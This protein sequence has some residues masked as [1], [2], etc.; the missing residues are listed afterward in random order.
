[1]LAYTFWH[2][3]RPDVSPET[4]EARQR[5][6]QATLAAHPPDGFQQGTTVRL[7]GAPWA[8]EGRTAY[9]DWYL[10]RDMASLDSL[11][12][13]A[14]T[15]ARQVPHDAVAQLAADGIAGLYRLRAGAPI[16][17]PLLATWFHKPAG[18][19]YPALFEALAS[20]IEAAK[21]A[22]WMRQM[23]LGPTPEFCLHS[24][25]LVKLPPGFTGSTLALTPIWTGKAQ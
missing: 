4:Y 15:A 24:N 10:V 14:V 2:W 25:G 21:A 11:N 19:S 9:E 1:V 23:T 8:A 6:F 3:K 17:P 20:V 22:L 5:D 7:E 18:M 12:Q 16:F 13:A